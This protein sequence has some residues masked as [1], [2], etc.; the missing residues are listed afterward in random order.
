MRPSGPRQSPRLTGAALFWLQ[1]FARAVALGIAH[2]NQYPHPALRRTAFM[3]R[4]VLVALAFLA[5]TLALLP[6]QLIGILFDLRLQRS[7]P[8]LCHRIL[9]ALIGVR[10]RQVGTRS[11]ASPALIL[12]NH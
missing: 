3:I 6:L 4:A 10:I 2:R 11:T 7:I 9:C 8:H 5:L 1:L 12:S